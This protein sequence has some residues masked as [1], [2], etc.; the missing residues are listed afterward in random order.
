MQFTLTAS[1]WP[2]LAPEANF[3]KE[4]GHVTESLRGARAGRV[5][6]KAT[7][8][9][10]LGRER[11]DSVTSLSTLDRRPCHTR[12]LV[13]HEDR[14]AFP[15]PPTPQQ[16]LYVRRSSRGFTRRP[17]RL[18]VRSWGKMSGRVIST[19]DL[20]PLSLHLQTPLWVCWV[21][22]SPQAPV[23]VLY[24]EWQWTTVPWVQSPF[25]DCV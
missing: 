10:R 8:P 21:Q 23:R 22:W 17:H 1:I 15:E 24:R 12:A 6:G 25:A 4:Y 5:R 9:G 3:P 7:S 18:S 2:L 16:Q 20:F 19:D 13:R 14:A 11:Q